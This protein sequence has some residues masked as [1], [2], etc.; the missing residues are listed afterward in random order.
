MRDA[1]GR[2]RDFT[3]ITGPRD[4]PESRSKPRDNSRGKN[5]EEC[6]RMVH[7]ALLP[8]RRGIEPYSMGGTTMDI[9]TENVGVEVRSYRT[10]RCMG[11]RVRGHDGGEEFLAKRLS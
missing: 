10:Q 6:W 1:F 2:A 8:G 7:D 5:P 9:A 3:F 4:Y 11:K